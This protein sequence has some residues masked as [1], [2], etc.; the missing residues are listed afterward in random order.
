MFLTLYCPARPEPP[1]AEFY[2]K[3]GILY[4]ILVLTNIVVSRHYY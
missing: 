4:N 1:C 2:Q 3:N